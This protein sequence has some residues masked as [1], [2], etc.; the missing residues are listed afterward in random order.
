M[1]ASVGRDNK[2][3]SEMVKAWE[4]LFCRYRGAPTTVPIYS[5]YLPQIKTNWISAKYYEKLMCSNWPLDKI[6]RILVMVVLRL[7]AHGK[8]SKGFNPYYESFNQLVLS[9]Q[10]HFPVQKKN[11]TR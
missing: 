11:A 10:C 1:N 9:S 3:S 7:S 5:I 4:F 2:P 6:L 8:D